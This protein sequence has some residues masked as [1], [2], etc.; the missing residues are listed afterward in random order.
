MDAND[1]TFSNKMGDFLAPILS[2]IRETGFF[3]AAIFMSSMTLLSL[4]LFIVMQRKLKRGLFFTDPIRRKFSLLWLASIFSLCFLVTNS[5]AVAFKTLIVEETD[6]PVVPDYIAWVSP[7]HFLIS[8]LALAHLWLFWRNRQTA[9]DLFLIAYVQIGLLGGYYIGLHRLTHE[10]IVLTDV[11]SGLSGI[12]FFIWFGA[13]NWD[14]WLRLF[15][16][17]GNA[18]HRSIDFFQH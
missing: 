10:P 4:I 7:L 8:S 16:S 18:K 17:T 2:V 11:T 15:S 3:E 6:Y 1:L 9:F 12:F 14:L 5:T 13:L